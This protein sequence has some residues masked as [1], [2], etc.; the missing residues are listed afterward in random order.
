MSGIARRMIGVTKGV[1]DPF[2][3]NTQVLLS[4]DGS[5]GS[6][7]FPNKGNS[8]ETFIAFNG[9]EI[10][11]AQSKFGGASLIMPGSPASGVYCGFSSELTLGSG[12]YTIEF[13]YYSSTGNTDTYEFALQMD[14]ISA[15]YLRFRSSNAGFGYRLQ[16]EW[17]GGTLS[18]V[19]AYSIQKSALQNKWSH[20][21]IVA[22]SG[23]MRLFVEGVEYAVDTSTPASGSSAQRTISGD[24]RVIVGLNSGNVIQIDEFRYTTGVARY[25]EDFTPPITAFPVS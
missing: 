9:A 24:G 13:F 12:D 25:T 7:S 21:A 22:D 1:S 5:D 19:I 8:G 20:I 4:F 10:D 2:W 6:T 23:T 15:E 17:S 3:E 18:D 14:N 11:T 16:L